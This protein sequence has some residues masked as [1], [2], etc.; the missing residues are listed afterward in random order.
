MVQSVHVRFC[1]SFALLLIL[2]LLLL[3]AGCRG[4][5][6]AVSEVIDLETGTHRQATTTTVPEAG[7]EVLPTTDA[8]GYVGIESFE[9]PLAALAG[10]AE[11]LGFSATCVYPDQQSRQH[12]LV[13]ASDHA[14]AERMNGFFCWLLDPEAVSQQDPSLSL[15]IDRLFD[16]KSR[17]AA[18]A[19]KSYS[20]P[21][22][23]GLLA[24]SLSQMLGVA[25]V[26][27]I[28][29]FIL[30]GYR[31]DYA[32][33]L[34]GNAPA[35]GTR[36]FVWGNI[37]VTYEDSIISTIWFRAIE[38]SPGNSFVDGCPDCHNS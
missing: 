33:R 7:T 28:L 29:D 26:Q 6:P 30:T 11:K 36:R 16:E 13:V 14:A 21:R 37:E 5:T 3:T 15:C 35:F 4:P 34:A 17:P 38:R 27:A 10:S 23:V 8:A 12:F 24:Q 1:R 20:D 22:V 9:K 31:E 2:P 32:R 25:D 19:N 18:L